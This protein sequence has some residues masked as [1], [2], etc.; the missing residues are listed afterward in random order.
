[1]PRKAS[2]P[3]H[4][5]VFQTRLR[6]AMKMRGVALTNAALAD[7]LR[8]SPQTTHNWFALGRSKNITAKDLFYLANKFKVNARWLYGEKGWDDSAPGAM[9][10]PERRRALA[11]YD[12][13]EKL[14][15]E[16]GTEWLD[17]WVKHGYD[18]LQNLRK[19]SPTASVPFPHKGR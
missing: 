10:D 2:E 6:E 12:E 11:C 19:R 3:R 16:H 13:L 18:T 8:K 5:T 17:G 15:T 9:L 1:M 7:F 4:L 14:D